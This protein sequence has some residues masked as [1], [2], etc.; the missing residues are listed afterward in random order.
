MAEI[1]DLRME[2]MRLK[3]QLK[4]AL[5]MTYFAENPCDNCRF[6]TF[7]RATLETPSEVGC[8]AHQ[9]EPQEDVLYDSG[10]PVWMCPAFKEQGE[11]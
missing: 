4:D 7:H 10:D 3:R 9:V 8:A 2:N 5:N 1:D 6:C 11:G